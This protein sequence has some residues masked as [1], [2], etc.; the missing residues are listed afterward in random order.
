MKKA[1][2]I[3]A[4]GY[5]GYGLCCR[6]LD[7]DV[8]VYAIDSIPKA[9]SLEEEKLLQVGRNANLIFTDLNDCIFEDE[10]MTDIDAVFYTLIDPNFR[11]KEE[12]I[13]ALKTQNRNML[14]KAIDHC[15]QKRC[16]FILLST[17]CIESGASQEDKLREQDELYVSRNDTLDYMIIRLPTLYGP[18]QPDNLIYQQAI[19]ATID[20]NEDSH[21]IMYENTDDLLYID[22]AIDGILNI[23]NKWETRKTYVL[24]SGLED[25]WKAGLRL[26]SE[27]FSFDE[28]IDEF[29]SNQK[30]TRTHCF[31]QKPKTSLE[32]GINNQFEYVKWLK[33][34][35]K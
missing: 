3:G 15:D 23:I 18:W 13:I 25:Q 12:D 17:T 22:D 34:R 19:R 9:E 21:F 32:K 2:V 33:K 1:I 30:D 24:S 26:I 16:K 14:E 8:I 6:L 7:D 31:I 28:I 11:I 5:V 10:N 4:L 20:K 35:L 27:S 29:K